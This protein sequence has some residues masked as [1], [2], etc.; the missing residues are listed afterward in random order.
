MIVQIFCTCSKITFFGVFIILFSRCFIGDFYNRCALKKKVFVFV[1][2]MCIPHCLNWRE[3]TSCSWSLS[4]LWWTD[5]LSWSA[6]AY[7]Q[8][9]LDSY[10]SVIK[11]CGLVVCEDNFEELCTDWTMSLNSHGV[12]Y[13]TCPRGSSC[14]VSWQEVNRLLSHVC[15]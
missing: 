13:F 2:F 10:K 8:A 1:L 9:S 11:A 15:P 7:K 3:H 4:T 5:E 6:P 14:T 12:V